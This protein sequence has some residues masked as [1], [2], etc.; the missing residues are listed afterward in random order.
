VWH[1]L[2]S[3]ATLAPNIRLEAAKR[4]YKKFKEIPFE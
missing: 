3:S 4:Q 1:L 2:S